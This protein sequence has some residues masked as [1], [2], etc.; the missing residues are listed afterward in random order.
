MW[1][2]RYVEGIRGKFTVTTVSIPMEKIK[3][4]RFDKGGPL[5]PRR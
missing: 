1:K 4:G 3:V 2:R 5:W